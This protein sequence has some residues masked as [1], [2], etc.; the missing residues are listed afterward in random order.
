M[1]ETNNINIELIQPLLKNFPVSDN[2]IS[3]FSCISIEEY[4]IHSHIHMELIYVAEGTLSVKV[5]VSDYLLRKG[6]FTIINPFELHALY[7]A[8]D[9]NKTCILE[10][11]SSFYDPCS[12][13]TIFVSDCH[14]YKD[15]SGEDFPKIL[16]TLKKILALH[17]TGIS[18]IKDLPLVFPKCA[19]DSSAQYEKILLRSFINYIELYFTHEYFLLSD[20][21]KNTL[22]DNSLQA[23]R[24]KTILCYFYENFPQ[25]I[26]LQD[27]ADLTFV[28]RY[29]ISHLVKSGSGLTFSDLLQHIRIEKAEV[30]LLGTD[31]PINQIVFELGFSSYRYF[32]QHFKNLFNMTPAAYRKKY[33][34]ATIR[35][36]DISYL[37][38]TTSADI[39]SALL[40]LSGD[41]NRS[42]TDGCGNDKHIQ[43]ISVSGLISCD[44]SNII[45]EVQPAQIPEFPAA[46]IIYDTPYFPALL[47]GFMG[48]D[49]KGFMENFPQFFQ[50]DAEGSP[51][52]SGL[53]GNIT[54][55]KIK[56]SSY[57]IK[58]FIR[59]LDGSTVKHIPGCIASSSKRHISFILYNLP[60]DIPLI[61]EETLQSPE[62]LKALEIAARSASEKK[63]VFDMEDIIRTYESNITVAEERSIK[64]DLDAFY[65]WQRLGCPSEIP[66][67]TAELL[68]L[69]SVPD[70]RLEKLKS[71]AGKTT[72]ETAVV[73]FGVK[74]IT[75]W[76]FTQSL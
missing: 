64:I 61:S 1:P 70:I 27:V 69:A 50:P 10:I 20:H 67:K 48:N 44:E 26:Q 5:G 19:K 37:E 31:M 63:Y 22:R 32:S 41:E 30:Y 17:L 66:E 12:E 53:P 39:A 11:N 34:T 2:C 14:L 60:D 43:T 18:E 16:D 36:R 6:E 46:S 35:Y 29:H 3:A 13:G 71:H 24:L 62:A 57:Y 73:P 54:S 76:D 59:S 28:N 33:Q 51:H 21:K 75:L 38:P 9:I 40:H 23:D 72:L 7:S 52:F 8:G 25:K 74:C 68:N 47:L 42:S 65:Q 15:A 4:P 56:K 49:I 55:G 58:E 45:P